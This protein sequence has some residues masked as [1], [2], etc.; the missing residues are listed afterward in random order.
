MK[1]FVVKK[2]DGSTQVFQRK[3][4]K[5]SLK[6]AGASESDS[7]NITK[8]IEKELFDGI[9]T[10]KIYSHAFSFLKK[11]KKQALY[12]YSLRRAIS[13][14]GPSGFPFEIFLAKVLEKNG[15]QNVKVGRKIKGFC[16]SHEV[17]IVAE[18][19]EKLMTAE[20]KFHNKPNIKTDVKVILYVRERFR[21]ILKSGFYA[22]KKPVYSVI[23]N[24]KF[25]SN[26]V[27]YGNCSGMYLLSWNYPKNENIQTMVEKAKLH[28][29][30]ALTSIS[31]TEKRYILKEGIV[32]CSDLIKNNGEKLRKTKVIPKSKIQKIIDE[33]KIVCDCCD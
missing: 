16:V 13:E 19:E 8:H 7:E 2:G 17:D 18:N 6:K 15:W 21:D 14:L 29:I 26:A 23:T 1:N 4:L 30:T 11:E 32:L 22:E 27:T 12:N 5:N 24:T 25:S 33:S 20:L 3:K 28:P 9:T 10:N 31:K